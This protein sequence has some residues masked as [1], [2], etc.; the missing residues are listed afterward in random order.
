MSVRV[1]SR[2]EIPLLIFACAAAHGA[3]LDLRLKGFGS[4]AWLPEDDLQRAI[5]GS[6]SRDGSLDLRS[7]FEHQSGAWRLVAEHDA[8][9]QF[10]DSLTA[11]AAPQ[12]MLDQTPTDDERRLLD[13]TWTLGDGD[14]YRVYHRFDRLAAE[15]RRSDWGLTIGRQA[16][17][18]GSGLV[19][20]PLDLYSPFAPT[21]VDRDYKPGDD[22]V[23]LDRLNAGG[24]DLQLLTVWRRDERGH[25][26]VDESSLGGKFHVFHGD[27][28]IET[29]IGRHYTDTVYGVSLRMPLGT[30][31]MRTDW[32]LTDLDGGAT[33]LSGIVNVDY[34]FDAFGKSWYVFGEYFRNGFGVS[35]EPLDVSSLPPALLV[36]LSR[37]EVFS[38]MKDYFAVGAQL[39]WHPLITQSATVIMNLHDGSTLWQTT[40]SYDASDEARLQAG[41]VLPVGDRGEEFGEIELPPIGQFTT[42]GAVQAYLRAVYYF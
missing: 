27:L 23:I 28:D 15:Y 20:Q 42:G 17:S 11:A 21:T 38:L 2:F 7:M 12:G 10:G 6:P 5:D 34:S 40:L 29:M 3:E 16:V 37:G 18:W 41:V 19:F 39:Q 32:L 24:S 31:L 4:I 1:R 25:R 14:D 33:K 26:D 9:Y 35:G 13:L 22:V 8:I 30:A 36:R